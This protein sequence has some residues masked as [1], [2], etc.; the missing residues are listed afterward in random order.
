MYASL[1]RKSW[2]LLH[3]R[4]FRIALVA[5][6]FLWLNVILPGH[7]RGVVALPGGECSQCEARV[8]QTERAC[9]AKHSH[10]PHPGPSAPSIPSDRCAICFFAARVSPAVAFDFTHP[11]LQLIGVQELPPVVVSHS[12]QFASTY[13]G[14]A[15]PSI[16]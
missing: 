14:R 1:A 16:G 3:S 9:C 11:P 15:P 4:G 10:V 8:E 5:F 7:R 13:L 2:H 6:Q 12:P